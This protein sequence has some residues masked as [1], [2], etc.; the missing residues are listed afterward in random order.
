[1][2]RAWYLGITADEVAAR[3]ILVGDPARVDLFASDLD[4]AHL[5]SQERGLR[6]VTGTRGG[7]PVTVSAFG[8]GAPIAAVVLEELVALGA[9]VVLRAG[10][11]MA[12]G[13]QLG[14]P[15]GAFV[16]AQAAL[17]GESTSNTYAPLGF[18]AAADPELN[19]HIVA[20]LNRRKAPY[21]FGTLASFDGF[22]TELFA[23]DETRRLAVEARLADLRR[24][25]VLA[26]DMETSVVLVAGAVLGVQAGSL[27]LVSVDGTSRA[28]LD[29]AERRRGERQ[30]VEV[31]L[32]AVVATPVD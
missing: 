29:E 11:A 23:A 25:R 6:T 27:C 12:V 10:T 31:A 8:M 20:E 1:M 3:C 4:G 15:L 5:V 2:R 18:P 21:R 19:G 26:V 13:P 28:R 16:V 9:R 24:L 14:T 30:L 32:A 17:R 22:Y 7:V